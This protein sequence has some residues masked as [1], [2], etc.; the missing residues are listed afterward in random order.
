MSDRSE[1]LRVVYFWKSAMHRTPLISLFEWTLIKVWCTILYKPH[2]PSVCDSHSNIKFILRNRIRKRNG[3]GVL[4][5][6]SSGKSIRID[7]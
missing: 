3:M 2:S 5:F 1:C 6:L 4:K 7:F